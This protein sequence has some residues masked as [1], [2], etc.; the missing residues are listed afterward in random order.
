MPVQDSA[1][2]LLPRVP[3]LVINAAVLSLTLAAGCLVPAV[4]LHAPAIAGLALLVAAAALVVALRALRLYSEQL[5]IDAARSQPADRPTPQAS[6]NVMLKL[7]ARLEFAPVALWTVMD[8]SA[9]P[10]NAAARRLSAPGRGVSPETLRDIART[11]RPGQRSMVSFD[12]ERGQE[13]AMLSMSELIVAGC[14]ERLLALMPIESELEAE[15][16]KA[17]RQL[18]HVLTHEIMNSLTPIAS[19]SQTAT[20]MLGELPEDS[21]ADID[22]ALQAIFRRATHLSQ[23]V[24]R[25]RSISQLPAPVFESVRVEHLFNRLSQLVTPGWEARGGCVVFRTEPRS[26]ELR[27]DPGQLEQAL[28]NLIQN[29]AQATSGVEHP[30]LQVTAALVRGSRMVVKV[31]DNGAGVTAGLESQI[32]TPFFST[33]K[34]GS[35]IGLTL[36]RDQIHAMGG[37]VRY[38]RRAGGGACFL[39]AF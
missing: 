14:E 17:W 10:L 23:F 18:V 6:D 2:R 9:R 26:L 13:R 8:G 25:Y 12:N 30:Q 7:E 16:L 29:A 33:K 27:A 20:E 35:G 39:L 15:T 34:D 11:S 5:A 28:L 38:S 4:V 24:A 3:R 19:L 21:R 22:T 1:D 37:T 31:M 36:V 32:F